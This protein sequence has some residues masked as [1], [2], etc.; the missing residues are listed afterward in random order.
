MRRCV[1]HILLFLVNIKYCSSSDD[2]GSEDNNIIIGS[3]EEDG[4]DYFENIY[5]DNKKCTNE[6]RI[7]ELNK[8]GKCATISK[9]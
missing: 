1:H 4:V 7:K 9:G 3:Q 2:A 8:E 6:K 5:D